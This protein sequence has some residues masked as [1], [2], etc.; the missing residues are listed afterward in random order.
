MLVVDGTIA[1]RDVSQ[2]SQDDIITF[3]RIICRFIPLIRFKDISP[4]DYMIKIKPY[5]EILSKEYRNNLLNY[6]MIPECKP[7]LNNLTSRYLKDIN[8]VIIDQR[9]VNLLTNWIDRN[10]ESKF[11]NRNGNTATEFHKK[12]DNRGATIIVLKTKNSERI[13]GEYNPLEWDPTN[14]SFKCMKDNF[15]SHLQIK[16]MSKWQKVGYSNG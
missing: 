16:R 6:Y 11:T 9:H 12:C 7:K 3:K 4:K 2:W 14:G 15:Y 5:E 1:D 8:S 10:E 13:I